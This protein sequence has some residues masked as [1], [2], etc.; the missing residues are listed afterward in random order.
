MTTDMAMIKWGVWQVE[1]LADYLCKRGHSKCQH[2]GTYHT[3]RC[4]SLLLRPGQCPYCSAD[5]STREERDVHV[6]NVHSRDSLRVAELEGMVKDLQ[7]RLEVAQRHP[8]YS[9]REAILTY[10]RAD[11]AMDAT[12]H[13]L[14]REGQEAAAEIKR[15]QTETAEIDRGANIRWRWRRSGSWI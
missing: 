2:C 11:E 8:L 14:A 6:S 5:Y 10:Q 15:L 12:V 4:T 1:G 3:G 9:V 7:G 13:R